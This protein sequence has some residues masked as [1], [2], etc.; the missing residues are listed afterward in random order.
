MKAE[1]STIKLVVSALLTILLLS[2]CSGFEFFSADQ[3]IRPPKLTGENALIQ[4]AFENAVG[5]DV[6]FISPI[7][8]EYRSAF[9]HV[10]I[11]NDSYEENLVFYTT[12]DSPNEVHI[13]FLKFDGEKWISFGDITGNGSDVY[14]VQFYDLD[15]SGTYEIAVC[16]AV[17][18]SQKSKTLSLYKV[19]EENNEQ[20]VSTLSVIQIFDYLIDDIDS[21]GQNELLYITANSSDQEM[22]F[23]ISLIKLSSDSSSFEFVCEVQLSSSVTSLVQY[24][25]DKANGVYR[26]FVDCVNYD[27]S[28]MTEILYYD[29]ENCV[30]TKA[31]NDDGV[32]L[33]DLTIRT[34]DLLCRDINNDRKIEIPV[35]KK[36]E[37][38][39]SIDYATG[40]EAPMTLISYSE[41][42][43]KSL[44]P[45]EASYFYPPE[46]NFRYNMDE[47]FEKYLCV[48]DINDSQLRFFVADDLSSPVFTVDFA[49][50]ADAKGNSE[51]RVRIFS[52]DDES[53]TENIIRDYGEIL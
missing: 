47:F 36:Y 9:V 14:N 12:P 19:S 37:G 20:T 21:D 16:W 51:F 33:S 30:F 39:L 24:L 11:D 42:S 22:P 32:K 41:I 46:K 25:S 28:Y 13:H 6:M 7:S 45:I 17:S 31:Q 23:K 52:N 8:G 44:V 50:A 27:G 2:S 3:L 18:D 10:D 38:S 40:T 15:K 29:N 1:F 43:E 5:K 35:E 48:Y 34:S 4:K 49:E 53:L 26:F